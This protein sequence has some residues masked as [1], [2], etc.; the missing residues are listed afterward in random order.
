MAEEKTR[1]GLEKNLDIVM[2]AIG[3]PN[4]LG[5]EMGRSRKDKRSSATETKSPVGIPGV[6]MTGESGLDFFFFF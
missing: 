2:W 6:K 3:T 5:G 1:S 4:Y